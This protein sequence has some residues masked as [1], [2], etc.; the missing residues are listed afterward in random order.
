MFIF[1]YNKT[2]VYLLYCSILKTTLD[3]IKCFVDII[4][5]IVEY[6]ET[7]KHLTTMNGTRRKF[8]QTSKANTK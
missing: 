2:T 6:D 7:D 3:P 4:Y 8:K 1:T 5:W